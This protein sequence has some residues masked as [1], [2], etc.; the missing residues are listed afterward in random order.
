M[1]AKTIAE[2]MLFFSLIANSI[3]TFGVVLLSNVLCT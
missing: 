3:D 2:A 1:M